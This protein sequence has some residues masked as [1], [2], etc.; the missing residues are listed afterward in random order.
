MENI[1][2]ACR[3]NWQYTEERIF[4]WWIVYSYSMVFQRLDEVLYVRIAVWIVFGEQ[5]GKY[6]YFHETDFKR[7][8]TGYS[9]V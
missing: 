6:G 4:V 5:S 9:R 7:L 8:N 1:G 2:L 3:F